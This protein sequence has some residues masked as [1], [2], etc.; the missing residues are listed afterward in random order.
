MLSRV[1]VTLLVAVDPIAMLSRSLLIASPR[2]G[3]GISGGLVSVIRGCSMVE[4]P[5]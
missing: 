5:A 4:F 1:L 3:C 2:E